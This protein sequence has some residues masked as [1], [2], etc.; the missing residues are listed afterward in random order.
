MT[1]VAT[2]KHIMAGQK[3]FKGGNI[4]L[5]GNILNIIE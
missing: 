1:R 5:G 4:S 2:E 3:Y